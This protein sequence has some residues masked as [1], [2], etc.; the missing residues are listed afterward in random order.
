MLSAWFPF[1]IVQ[2]S[3]QGYQAWLLLSQALNTSFTALSTF[4]NHDMTREKQETKAFFLYFLT[5][6]KTFATG[7]VPQEKFPVRSIRYPTYAVGWQDFF[8]SA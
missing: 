1:F 2:A 7:C 6:K 8:G 4:S 5:F 3:W